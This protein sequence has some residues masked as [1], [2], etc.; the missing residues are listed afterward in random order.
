MRY[1]FPVRV[2]SAASRALRWLAP[3]AGAACAGGLV[4]GGA[5]AVHAGGLIASLATA[6]FVAML[7]LP[8]YFAAA[9][10]VRALLVAWKPR[11]LIGRLVEPGGAA[12]MFAAWVIVAFGGALALA[13]A[14]FGGTWLSASIAPFNG[15]TV[16]AIDG[17]IALL[18]MLVIAAVS[19][20]TARGVAR[21]ARRVPGDALRPRNIVIA[22]LVL[23][24]AGTLALWELAVA[25]RLGPL[26]LSPLLIPVLGAAGVVLAHL[27]FQRQIGGIAGMLVTL[28]I[29]AAFYVR[30]NEPMMALEIW[31]DRPVAGL[32]VD[33]LFDL[34]EIRGSVVLTAFQPSAAEGAAHPDIVLVTIDTVRADHT[35]PYGGHAEMPVLNALA[36]RGTTFEWAFSPSNVTRRSIPS[37]VIGLAPNR[38]RGRVVGWALRVDPRYVLLAERLRAAGYETAGFMCCSG[39]WGPEARTGLQRGLE[40]VEIDPNGFTLSGKAR[41]WL[42]RRNARPGAKKPLFV[43]MHLLEPHNWTANTGE[44]RNDEERQTFYN[45]ALQQSDRMLGEL[46]VPFAKS[47]P[48]VIVSADHGEALG[49]HGQPF[50]STDLYNSQTHVPLV[51]AGPGIASGRISET[52]SLTDLVP[53]VVDLAGYIAPTGNQIDGRSIAD[54]ARGTRKP[55]PTAGDAFIDMIKD[56]SNPGG[57]VAVVRG[58]WKLIDANGQQELYDVHAD[59]DEKQN[60]IAEP[61]LAPILAELRKRLAARVAGEDRS[62]F[63]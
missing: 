29:G 60:R 31:G 41:T 23:G 7:A 18:A 45:R 1:N 32:A 14:M 34:D 35:P 2:L 3:S 43:W 20:P 8:V 61:A 11:A 40:H 27:R 44:P 26:D 58:G 55:D 21:L 9:L 19:W 54:L 50:H 5:E 56:R 17:L 52:V 36:G 28:V 63:E 22:T 30:V 57:I 16:G 25:P 46:L 24:L 62:P 6:G 47:P 15:L 39:F 53:T 51:I 48:I 38:V 49:D 12:P 10:A 4:A 59:P 33:K 37:M 42:D 13:A